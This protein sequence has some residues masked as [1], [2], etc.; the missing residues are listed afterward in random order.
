VRVESERKRKEEVGKRNRKRKKCGKIEER[1]V[2][3]E[4]AN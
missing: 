3:R 4:S 2:E 1:K